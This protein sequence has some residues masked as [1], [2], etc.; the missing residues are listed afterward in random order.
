MTKRCSV[1]I[2]STMS[3]HSIVHIEGTDIL[4]SN[5][6]SYR[7]GF[8]DKISDRMQRKMRLLLVRVFVPLTELFTSMSLISETGSS[9]SES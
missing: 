6:T 4:L 1:A 3:M 2:F 7:F 5:V 9:T 8:H